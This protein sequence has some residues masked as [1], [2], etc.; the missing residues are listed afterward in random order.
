MLAYLGRSLSA[1]RI[2]YAPLHL[3]QAAILYPCT[4]SQ[5]PPVHDHKSLPVPDKGIGVAVILSIHYGVINQFL[6]ILHCLLVPNSLNKTTAT[7]IDTEQRYCS[8]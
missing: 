5:I 4:I 8:G 1:S 6:H 3:Y 7:G 2:P